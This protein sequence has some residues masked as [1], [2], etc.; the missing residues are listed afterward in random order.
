MMRGLMVCFAALL[1][2]RGAFAVPGF[3]RVA[4]EPDGRWW[5][6]TPWNAHFVPLGVDHVNSWGFV[7]ANSKW[8]YKENVQAKY[9]SVKAWGEET[10]KRLKDWNFN[11]PGGTLRPHVA[12]AQGV[13]VGGVEH[14]GGIKAAS[15]RQQELPSLRARLP[16]GVRHPT[17]HRGFT[18]LRD[19]HECA[20]GADHVFD[21]GNPRLC[22]DAR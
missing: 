8:D 18:W 3:Y 15:V 22:E 6:Y 4:K 20:Q 17:H 13:C 5:C 9:G 10:L 11:L 14:R 1:S 21:D 12:V 16:R 19:I 7:G 2:V